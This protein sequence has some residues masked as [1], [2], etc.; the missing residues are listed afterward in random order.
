MKHLTLILSFLF[1]SVALFGQDKKNDVV[2]ETYMVSGNC[3]ECKSRIEKAAYVK[4]VKRADWNKE[5]K[6]LTVT[7]K[8]DKTSGEEILKSVAEAGY[9]SEKATASEES[10]AKLPTCC[11]YRT[12]SCGD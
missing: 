8:T 3:G 7:Y 11:N 5:T 4:G 1:C 6:K 9:D 12:G 2:T 10:Y